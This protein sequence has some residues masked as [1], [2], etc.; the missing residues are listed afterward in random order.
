MKLSPRVR[1]SN[2]E[3]NLAS[4]NSREAL[5][6]ILRDSLGFPEWYGRNWDAFWDCLRDPDLSSSPVRLTLLGSA[7]L[8]EVLPREYRLFRKC[9]EDLNREHPD[10]GIH[11]TW[12]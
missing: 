7:H 8:A 1:P 4:V 10:L 2:L 12:A 6:D 11:V 3:I 9:L 5:H